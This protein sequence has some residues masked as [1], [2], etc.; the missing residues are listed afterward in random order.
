MS[1]EQKP[2]PQAMPDETKKSTLYSVTLAICVSIIAF[3]IFVNW[4]RERDRMTEADRIAELKAE[5][6]DQGTEVKRGVAEFPPEL[7]DPTF[8]VVFGRLTR[9]NHGPIGHCTDQWKGQPPSALAR[10]TTDAVGG[11]AT[12]AVQ[13]A[14]DHVQ[15]CLIKVMSKLEFPWD[16][17]AVVELRLDPSGAS[18]EDIGGVTEPAPDLSEKPKAPTK[19]FLP[20]NPGEYTNY[21]GQ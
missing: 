17:D 5:K 13:G 16:T 15:D 19:A 10:I 18:I 1:E 11:L 3:S 4:K 8:T 21:Q 20:R 2:T 7:M 6:G 14:P 12:L 9:D